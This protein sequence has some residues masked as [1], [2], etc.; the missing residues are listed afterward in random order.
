MI[1]GQVT[2]VT[3]RAGMTSITINGPDGLPVTRSLMHGTSVEVL[4]E[5]HPP[6]LPG[7]YD[8]PAGSV[9]Q[10]TVHPDLSGTI[11]YGDGDTQDVDVAQVRRLIAAG[12]QARTTPTPTPTPDPEPEPAPGPEITTAR[13]LIVGQYVTIEP[14]DDGYPS[15]TLTGR[16][17]SNNPV[18]QGRYF[19]HVALIDQDGV[20]TYHVISVS[21]VAVALLDPP[22]PQPLPPPP[23]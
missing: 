5:P 10:L 14:H 12:F 6:V 23:Q 17:T 15:T 20:E 16:V 3:T 7:L 9:G 8:P 13:D 4:P 2:A 22:E 18:G 21:A 1:D 19:R 11:D